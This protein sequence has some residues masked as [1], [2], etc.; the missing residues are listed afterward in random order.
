MVCRDACDGHDVGRMLALSVLDTILSMDKFQQWM[1]F[2]SSK[3]YLQHLVDSLLH[4]DQPLQTLVSPTPQL[5]VL[6]IYLSKLTESAVGA[7]TLLQ[8]GVMQRLAGCVFFDLRP[9]FDR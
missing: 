9:D 2:L 8:C 7:H 6:Y 1:T 5:R 4:D 3:G